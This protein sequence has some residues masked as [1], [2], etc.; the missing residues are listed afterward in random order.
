MIVEQNFHIKN[1]FFTKRISMAKKRSLQQGDPSWQN[2]LSRSVFPVK[3][4]S[5]NANTFLYPIDES[6]EYYDPFS[7]LSLFLAK[8][9]TQVVTE[10]SMPKH[11][12]TKVQDLLLSKILPEFEKE[13][14]RYRLGGSALK[15]IFEKV[16][17]YQF[18]MQKEQLAYNLDGTINKNLLIREN[19]KSLYFQQDHHNIHPYHYSH[20]LAI[21][22]SECI[23]TLDGI[24]IPIDHLTK[25]IW[26]SQKHLLPKKETI[27]KA[28][29]ESYDV[30]DKVLLRNMLHISLKSPDLGQAELESALFQSIQSYEE[31]ATYRNLD[32]L[33]FTVSII[34]GEMMVKHL[35]LFRHFSSKKIQQIEQF[36][37]GQIKKN[38]EQTGRVIKQSK[39]SLVQRIL[40]LY[41]LLSSLPK[42]NA[43]AQL[44]AAIQYVYSLSSNI[45]APMSQFMH[46]SILSFINSEIVLIKEKKELG[47]LEKVLSSLLSTFQ[48]GGE[49]PR[50]NDKQ[51]SELECWIWHLINL[52]G[53]HL[54]KIPSSIKNL[55]ET[56]IT[57]VLAENGNYSFKE[58]I[59]KVLQFLKGVGNLDCFETPFHLA[60]QGKSLEKLKEKIYLFSIQGDLVL[61]SL[62]LDHEI[63]LV[64]EG[65]K[66]L[67]DLETHTVDEVATLL[68]EQY[69]KSNP[70]LHSCAAG[71]KNHALLVIKYLWYKKSYAD[72]ENAHHRFIKWHAKC[73]ID[74]GFHNPQEV[75]TKIRTL[76]E[77]LT[78]LLPFDEEH[79]KIE[80]ATLPDRKKQFS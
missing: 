52:E 26:S 2:R 28:P 42:E 54:D 74:K 79:L 17:F 22:I 6:E 70:Y 5:V 15:R 46:Q 20:Q 59:Q 45:F 41:P 64:S 56:E 38:K 58:I 76:S 43:K 11:W 55:I 29:F 62:Q 60:E 27:R 10:Q 57:H 18:K 30:M 3:K 13:F 12:S 50:M 71:L 21:K 19:L 51:L 14:P 61:S 36:V 25:S 7:D 47:A 9:I 33:R 44:N 37:Q 80:L 66:L 35:S 63:P 75:I 67:S 73:E 4:Q 48:E 77:K 40:A 24:R 34:L 65:E 8:K 31:L 53:N 32:D 72:K 69:T 16:H 78:P 49:L 68:S 39:I 1:N 23:A